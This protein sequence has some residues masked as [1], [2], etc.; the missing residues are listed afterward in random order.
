MIA[1]RHLC[2]PAVLLLSACGSGEPAVDPLAERDPAVTAALADPLMADPDLTSQNRGGAALTGGGP[3]TGEIPP[4]KRGQAELD[5]ARAAALDLVGGAPGAAPPATIM[6]ETSPA[7]A[8]TAVAL[9]RALPWGKP[10]AD[11]LGYTASWA[12][13]L[14]PAL[15]VYPRGH[16]QEAAGS[17]AAGCKIRAV[18][19]QTPVPPGEV[20]EFY[21]ALARKG[22]YAVRAGQ[23]GPDL[24]LSGTLDTARFALFVRGSADMTVVNLVTSGG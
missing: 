2:L 12:A 3:A 13:G 22:G 1:A 11:K 18:N 17:D 21:A 16:V 10:C 6:L 5:A 15:P 20:V 19:F 9:V 4:L 8:P 23:A 24:T 14:P 7:D